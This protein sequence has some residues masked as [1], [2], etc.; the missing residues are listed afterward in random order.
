MTI[1]T[2]GYGR[3]QSAMLELHR[4]LPS[5]YQ[6]QCDTFHSIEPTA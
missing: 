2:A 4:R 5:Y 3:R 1:A 6:E